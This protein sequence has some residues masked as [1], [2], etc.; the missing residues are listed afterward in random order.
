MKMYG[1]KKESKEKSAEVVS[2]V[3]QMDSA[4]DKVTHGSDVVPSKEM[5]LVT[6]WFDEKMEVLELKDGALLIKVSAKDM[7]NASFQ[8]F[9][10]LLRKVM[11]GK[12]FEAV[13]IIVANKD[14]DISAL[15]E[16]MMY[17]AGWFGIEKLK[18]IFV[19]NGLDTKLLEVN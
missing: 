15:S 2:S 11:D 6:D 17:E 4:V 5:R 16:K 14:M 13:P 19:A 1:D 12:G 7:N 9:A 18:K 3:P 8:Q 10:G